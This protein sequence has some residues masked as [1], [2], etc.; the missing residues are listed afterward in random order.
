MVD[1]RPF[2]PD[3]LSPPGETITTILR[4]RGLTSEDFAR[5][6]QLAPGEVSQLLAGQAVL[7][8]ELARRLA[9]VFGASV[10]FWIK[11]E[12]RYREDLARLRQEALRAVGLKWLNEL[13]TKDMLKWGWVGP[14]SDLATQAALVLQFFGVS[15][16][17]S[18]RS[19]YGNVLHPVAFR[20][21]STF[22]T[23]PGALVA[24]L[25]QGEILAS[26]IPCARW[27]PER[28]RLR[29]TAFLDLTRE[30][31]P[32]VFLPE[33]RRLCATCGVALVILRTP[34]KCPASGAS[35]FLSPTRPLLMLSFRYLSDDHFWFTFFHEVAHLLLHADKDLF[36]EGRDRVSTEEEEEADTF[37]A[38][39]LI[40]PDYHA[41]MFRLPARAVPVVRF[42]HKVGVSP[43]IVVGQLQ[44]RGH[45]SYDQLNRLKR[46][47][48]WK[49]D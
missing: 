43:G 39:L 20:T 45:F 13:P 34:K 10:D 9:G 41:E 48:E 12:S 4:E 2:T 31:D 19:T 21:S 30:K 8:A 18:W 29:L 28:L 15:S 14:A 17:E 7:T 47:Y 3:W 11:R 24:W 46:R 42:A 1:D 5:S 37:A 40:P 36:L 6:I 23:Q 32:E 35:R 26:S 27:S 33:L 38:N 44:H 16:V 22:E 49:D 25:R